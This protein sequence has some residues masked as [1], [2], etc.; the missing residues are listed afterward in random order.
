MNHS[1]G[2]RGVARFITLDS[3]CPVVDT[4]WQSNLVVASG[5][6]AIAAILAGEES[7]QDCR[8]AIGTGTTPPAIGDITLGAEVASDAYPSFQRDNA[9]WQVMASFITGWS[10]TYNEAGLF[11]GN[12]MVSRILTTGSKTAS[13][14]V[15]GMWRI[16]FS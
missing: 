7:L 8:M 11:I 10:G 16:T 6:A 1:I 15:V 5:P 9:T 2:I 13:Q 12:R 14:I 3:G 4:G